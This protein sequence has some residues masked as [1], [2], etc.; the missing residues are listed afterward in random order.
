MK[1]SICP[2]LPEADQARLHAVHLPAGAYALG[3]SMVDIDLKST[4]ARLSTVRRRG[5][6]G[7]VAADEQL[8]I[9]DTILLMGQS[10]CGNCSGV[11]AAYRQVN[12]SNK[13]SP[14]LRAFFLV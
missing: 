1:R 10:G 5:G 2:P 9:G 11:T 3:R 12:S 4:H 13:K 8:Q 14:L 7:S 6:K